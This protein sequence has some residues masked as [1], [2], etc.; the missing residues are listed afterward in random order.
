MRL[1]S[2]FGSQKNRGQT[3]TIGE[4]RALFKEEML[5]F[6]NKHYYVRNED[7]T[8]DLE[9]AMEEIQ[10]NWHWRLGME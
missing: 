3:L 9:E 5:M 4:W 6:Q 2:R 10:R 1:E 8:M 7:I